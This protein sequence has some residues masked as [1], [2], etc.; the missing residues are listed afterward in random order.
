LIELTNIWAAGLALFGVED[1]CSI[2]EALLFLDIAGAG[3]GVVDKG[4]GGVPG[5]FFELAS[6]LNLIASAADIIGGGSRTEVG[7][8]AGTGLEAGMKAF[9]ELSFSLSE[10][11]MGSGGVP[12][13]L[14]STSV[15]AAVKLGRRGYGIENGLGFFRGGCVGVCVCVCVRT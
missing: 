3:V 12:V 1:P 8:W 5:D 10:S 11:G 6:F 7:V 2:L 4:R 13:S 9:G 14:L 15:V